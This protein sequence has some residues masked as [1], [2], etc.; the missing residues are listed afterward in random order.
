MLMIMAA[1]MQIAFASWWTLIKN[2]AVEGIGLT[3]REIGFQESIREIPGFLSFLAIYVLF[4]MREQ[5]LALVSLAL[6][7][8]GVAITGWFPSAWGLYATTLLMSLGFHYYETMNQSLALQWLP[9]ADAPRIMGR[10]LAVAGFAQLIAYGLIAI[11]WKAFELSFTAV[12]MIAGG[13]TLAIVVFLVFAF[14]NFREETPQLKKLVL[15]RRY[16]LY[17]ALTF[18]AGARRQIFTVFAGLM[19]VQKFGYE[20]DDIALL[21]LVNC[22]F[23]MIFAPKIGAMIGRFG[24]RAALTVEYVGLIGVF[25]AYAFVESAW[26]AAG[27]YVVDHAFFAMAIAIKTYFQKIASPADIAPSAGVAFTINHIAAVGIPASFGFIWLVSPSAVFLIGAAMAAGSLVLVRLI[28]RH[29][30]E[31]VEVV[32]KSRPGLAPAE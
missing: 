1:A 23:N 31:G 19:M 7:G 8:I 15:R 5:T 25:L 11:G 26:L 6:L 29:P 18:L 14:P 20:V 12:F 16:W 17:Y 30:E 24:E 22:A 10:I 21:F 28:P 32:W 2:F 9:R 13:A 4:V 27:L 3:G